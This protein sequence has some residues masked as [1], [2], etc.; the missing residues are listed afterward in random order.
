MCLRR[1]SSTARKRF[2]SSTSRAAEYW[3]EPNVTYTFDFYQHMILPASFELDFGI[4]RF[5]LARCLNQQPVQMMAKVGALSDQYLWSV[6]LWHL[7]QLEAAATLDD[8]TDTSGSETGEHSDQMRQRS[9][10]GPSHARDKT[11]D[12]E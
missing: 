6:E 10:S 5:N 2:F 8:S 9:M 7:R 11:G 3:F 1:F 12:Q 4:A